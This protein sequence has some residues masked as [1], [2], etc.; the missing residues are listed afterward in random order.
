MART[1]VGISDLNSFIQTDAAINPG[2][3]GGALVTMDGRLV[4]INS[5]IFSKSGGSLGIGFAIPSNMV[6]SVVASL[7]NE[8]QVIRPWLGAWG[9]AVNADIAVSL[10]MPRP[11]GVLV[12]NVYSGGPADRAGLSVGD[13]ILAV[14]GR[15]INDTRDLRYRI[16]TLPVGQ[17][18]NLKVW[19][20]KKTSVI[21]VALEVPPEDPPADITELAGVNP[22]SG[23]TVANI[24]PALAVKLRLG[25]FEPG[26]I[27]LRINRGS[28]ARRLGFNRGDMILS[29]NGNPVKSVSY[30][31]KFLAQRLGRFEIAIKRNGKTIKRVFNR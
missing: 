30:L 5:A 22:L 3:S 1:Q 8:G 12:S 27:I 2:N 17:S 4:G 19:R 31:K 6:R 7:V 16:A 21:K 11:S 18:T 29:I 25:S 14:N 10:G 15:E 26:V 24:S 23:S 20:N 13:I 9:Q 28:S